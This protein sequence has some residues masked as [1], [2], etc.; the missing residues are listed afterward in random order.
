MD[1]FE[2]KEIGISLSTEIYMTSSTETP[3]KKY[4]HYT[5]EFKEEVCRL[6]LTSS[7]KKK[8]IAAKFDIQPYLITNW[9][10]A[11][12]ADGREAFRGR[13][14]RKELEEENRKLRKQIEDL[15]QEKEIL[16]KA[17]AYFA[18]NLG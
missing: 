10:K 17:T 8:E 12:K 1:N 16:K 15:K 4:K 18:K 9:L 11:M 3:K 13:G 14:T 6:A 7:L 5:K 2:S